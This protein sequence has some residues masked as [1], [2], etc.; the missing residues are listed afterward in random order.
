[1][2]TI[3]ASSMAE[4][5]LLVKRTF[6]AHGVILHTRSYK[7][8]GVLGFG[9]RSVVEVTCAD[10]RELGKRYRKKAETSPRA[11]AL[12]QRP[13]A[14]S[15]TALPAARPPVPAPSEAMAVTATRSGRAAACSRR[16]PPTLR[17]SNVPSG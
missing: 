17:S 1:M 16:R 6:G 2:K 9:G 8:G 12:A 5:L 11:Q 10:G 15:E 14:R 13:A 4:A 3:T 7:R